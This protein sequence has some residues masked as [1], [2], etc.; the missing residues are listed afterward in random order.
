M[1]ALALKPSLVT[2]LL[3]TVPPCRQESLLDPNRRL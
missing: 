3:V 1:G 2:T